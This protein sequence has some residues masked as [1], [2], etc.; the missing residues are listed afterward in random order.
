[1]SLPQLAERT[2]NRPELVQFV[3]FGMT[4]QERSITTVSRM[5]SFS[6]D[7]QLTFSVSPLSRNGK[8]E[9]GTGI[10]TKASYSR[11][12]WDNNSYQRTFQHSSSNLPEMSINDG[13]N[14]FAWFIRKFNRQ[15]NDQIDSFCCLTTNSLN[16]LA[17]KKGGED[18]A[19]AMDTFL[20]S[21]I[22]PG[23][24]MTYKN[25]GSNSNV[26]I[27]GSEIDVD[28]VFK[29]NVQFPDASTRL[30]TR[31]FLHRPEQPEVANIPVT[32]QNYRDATS[33]LSDEEL[34][35]LANPM[36]LTPHEQEFLDMH[37]RLFHLP[38]TVM[39]RLAKIDILPKYFARLQKRPPPCASC[40]FG[41]AH[42]RPWRSKS[43]K[44]GKTSVL[45]SPEVKQPGQCIAVDQIVSAQP[46]LV[47]QDKGQL[48][49][50]RIWGCTV[51]VDYAESLVSVILMRDLGTESTMAA[52]QEFEDKC[53]TRGVRVQHYHADNGRFAEPAWKE[54]CKQKGQKLTFCGVGAHHQNAIVE[55][56]IKDLTLTAR[57]LLLH[58]M[59]YWPEYT[60]P[61]FCGHSQSNVQKIALITCKLTLTV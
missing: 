1:M 3:G 34:D 35:K 41:M 10:D 59:R 15:C 61:K 55:R 14:A 13:S 53:A 45:R 20:E 38:Y 48:T 43:T 9:D 12:Y 58:A 21:V 39:F 28:G 27:L 11:F 5:Y 24:F 37:N 8:D 17:N 32:T 54:D 7:L 6:Q 26:K 4:I 30:V 33:T 46:G 51:F 57:T 19:I 44:D 40:L 16:D 42:R 31:E 25:E 56:K 36:H 47:P 52:K 29:Y 22:Y 23:E 49:R 60:S 2:V 18:L 50:S